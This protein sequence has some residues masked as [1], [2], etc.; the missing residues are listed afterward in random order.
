[1]TLLIYGLL[2][3]GHEW[4]YFRTETD[5]QILKNLWLSKGTG[6]GWEVEGW[7]GA[8]GLASAH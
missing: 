8:V 6:V 1:M 3:K 5:S 4:T 2:K 7:T